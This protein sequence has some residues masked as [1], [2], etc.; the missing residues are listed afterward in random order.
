MIEVPKDLRKQYQKRRLIRSLKT[1]S[2][3]D[4]ERLKLPVISE[5]KEEFE[6]L[7]H[8]DTYSM[9]R[10]AAFYREAIP[11]ADTEDRETLE[12]VLD[13][14]L[15]AMHEKDP[16]KA[17]TYSLLVRGKTTQMSAHL[18]S[19]LST[20]N[21][22]EKTLNMKRTDALRFIKEFP[23]SHQ[24]TKRT[25]QRWADQL[26]AEP[27]KPT[28][29][30]RILSACRG[31]W[32][33]LDRSGLIDRDDA[34]FTN[35]LRKSNSKNGSE[36]GKRRLP[37]TSEQVVALLHAAEKEGDRSL[38]DLLILAMWT[39]CRIEE[40]CS[41]KKDAIHSD[42]FVINEAKTE[43]G[44]RTVPVHSKL[45]P[46]LTRMIADSGDEYVLDGLTF[47]KYGNRSNAIGKRFGRLKSK[48]GFGPNLVFHSIRKTVATQLENAGVPENVTA[49][50][51]GHEKQTI[52]Y[53]LYSGGTGLALMKEAIEELRYPLS[54]KENI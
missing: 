42:H 1:E 10:Q 11:Q 46:E 24:V 52:T 36:R 5:W 14:E 31:Y 37:F 27:L 47:N 26:L 18:D 40:L 48:L 50:I 20:C 8:G 16:K 32:D 2:L 17:E 29:V 34:P 12:T 15:W 51:L 54:P 4:A 9:E 25:V 23:Y 45:Q 49:D 13:D 38:R 39:G 21:N 33:Y 41:L 30:N 28:T 7:R 3:T 22:T 43:A 35:T 6:A 53:G 19:W 44:Q